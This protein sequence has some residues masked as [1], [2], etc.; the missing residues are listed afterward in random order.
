MEESHM[1]RY[2][3]RLNA[4]L[5]LILCSGVLAKEPELPCR[6]ALEKL[7][8]EQK[9][10][11]TT[12]MGTANAFLG[13]PFQHVKNALQNRE[14]IPPVRNLWR[15]TGVN[16]VRSTPSTLPE[17]MI[18]GNADHIIKKVNLPLSCDTQ[19]AGLAFAAS[20]PGTVLNTMAEQVVMRAKD[21]NSCYSIIKNTLKIAGPRGFF[22]GF[23]PKFMRDGT[24]S[25]AYWYAAPKLKAEYK[26]R[27]LQEPFATIA[28]GVSVAVPSAIITHP[29]D[30]I[31]TAMQ[32]D[33]HRLR[34]RH[35][36]QSMYSF[37]HTHGAR[38]LFKGMTPRVISAAMRI[39]ILISL[40]DKL[41][42]YFGKTKTI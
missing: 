19:K 23:T 40:Q 7:T 15:G 13:T 26:N 36:A 32:N 34:Y 25:L 8:T 16:I 42:N 2:I 21:G 14:P 18:M 29:F 31:S 33:M 20:L 10:A 5:A 35:T 30:T 11:V 22:R 12:A 6:T 41:T 27:G 3:F 9:I 17:V 37:T 39:P 38:E 1:E 24:G 4:L 28:A